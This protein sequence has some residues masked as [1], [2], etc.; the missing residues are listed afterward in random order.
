MNANDDYEFSI[1]HRDDELD[2][3]YNTNNDS[4]E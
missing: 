2:S 3:M 4:W 1:M